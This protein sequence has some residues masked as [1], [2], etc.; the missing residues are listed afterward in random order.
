MKINAISKLLICTFVVNTL[1]QSRTL[2]PLASFKLMSI[3]PKLQTELNAH[4]KVPQLIIVVIVVYP[5]CRM[6]SIDRD[7]E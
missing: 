3:L 5:R 6:N 4:L 1:F 2:L 7:I